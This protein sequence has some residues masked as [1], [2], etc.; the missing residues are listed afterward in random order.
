MFFGKPN[1]LMTRGNDRTILLTSC[2]GG[3]TTRGKRPLSSQRY[4]PCRFKLARSVK[5]M[6]VGGKE[7]V[8]DETKT[9]ER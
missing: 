7:E 5:T 3:G 4:M 1:Q 9:L 8:F 2:F 6:T